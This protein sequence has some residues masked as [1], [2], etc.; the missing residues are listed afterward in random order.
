MTPWRRARGPDNLLPSTVKRRNERY[1]LSARLTATICNEQGE[2][3][4]QTH[5]LDISESGIGTLAG[6]GWVVGAH[7]D[8][9]VPLPSENASLEIQGIVRHRTGVRCGLEFFEVTTDQQRVLQNVCR[10]LATR[11]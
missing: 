9:E 7:V 5:A 8:L 4:M 2:T 1:L 10:V 11:P 3:R 6:E